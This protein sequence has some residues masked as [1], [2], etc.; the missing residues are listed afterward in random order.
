VKQGDHDTV[1]TKGA[2]R[3]DVKASLYGVNAKEIALSATDAITL[4]VGEVSIR[5]DP[6]SIALT[7]DK[8]AEIKLDLANL[9]RPEFPGGSKT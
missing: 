8:N 5:I 4:R 6:M 7:V 2:M 1:V 9:N 3:A